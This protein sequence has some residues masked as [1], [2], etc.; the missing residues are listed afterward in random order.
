MFSPEVRKFFAQSLEFEK[1]FY[2]LQKNIP[3]QNV[4]LKP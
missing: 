4:P 3:P 2:F 1:E